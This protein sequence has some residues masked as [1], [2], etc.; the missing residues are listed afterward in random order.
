MSK[1][2][3]TEDEEPVFN[4]SQIADLEVMSIEALVEYIE[5]L[6]MEIKRV[7]GEIKIKQDARLGAQSIFKS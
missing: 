3:D 7:E 1:F 2:I 5:E 4:K 6:R